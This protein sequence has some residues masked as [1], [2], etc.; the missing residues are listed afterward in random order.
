M[1]LLLL[2]REPLLYS[3]QRLKQAAEHEGHTLDIL[4]PNR[5]LLKLEQSKL[6]AYYQSGQIYDKLRPAPQKIPEYQGVIGR[7]GATSTTIGCTLLRH[8]E[9]QNIACL[10]HS[11]AFELARDKWR[12]LQMLYAAGIPVPSTAFAGNLVAGSTLAK[13]F[14]PPVVIKTLSGSQGIGV[15]LSENSKSCQSLLDTFIATQIPFLTQEFI[16]EAE[17]RDIRA[18]VLG[19]KVI[20]A[21][22]RQGKSGDFRANIHQGG[23][24]RKIE[25]SPE[26]QALAIQATSVIG[27]DVAGVDLIRTKQGAMVLEVNAAP[28]LEMIEQISGIDIAS[29][30]INYL[31]E[32]IKTDSFATF[33]RKLSA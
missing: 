18:F 2:C 1:Q 9:L 30:M 32:K 23:S 13:Q 4:D 6:V 19:G 16:R 14:T 17:G 5:F 31:Y 21:M 12:S 26:E 28:G 29:K 22:E 15:M 20:A 3:C 8:F 10:N 11:Q 25:L 27:L 7:F 33:P 24:A